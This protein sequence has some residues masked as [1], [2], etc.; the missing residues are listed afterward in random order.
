MVIV[1]IRFLNIYICKIECVVIIKWYCGFGYGKNLI[2]VI[3]I[4]VKKY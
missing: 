1:R 4:I 2:Y 3:E